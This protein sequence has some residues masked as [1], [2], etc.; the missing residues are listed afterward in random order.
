MYI[1]NSVCFLR[2]SLGCPITK[3]RASL[4]CIERSAQNRSKN[5]RKNRSKNDRKNRSNDFSSE[6]QFWIKFSIL[7]QKLELE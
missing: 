7:D 6:F 4:W 5:Y 2:A 1:C 3:A